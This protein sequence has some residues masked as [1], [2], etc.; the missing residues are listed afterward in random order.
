MLNFDDFVPWS[1]DITYGQNFCF[2]SR[3]QTYKKK[4]NLAFSFD[5]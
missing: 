4:L 1:R 3:S 5:F 2:I